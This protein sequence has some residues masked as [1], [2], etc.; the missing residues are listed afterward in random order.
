MSAAEYE[1]SATDW[2]GSTLEVGDG[3][4]P[5]N[6]TAIAEVTKITFGGMKTADIETT[7][8][9]SP[10]AHE[11]NIPGKRSTDAFGV[12]GNWLPDNATQSNSSSGGGGLTYL[13][14]TR[15]IR[16]FQIVM[17]NSGSPQTAWPFRGYVNMFKPGDA[18]TGTKK[19]FEASIKPSKDIA[20]DLP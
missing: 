14:R 4:S 7:H 8:L 11:E 12:S 13:A 19:S 5:E 9:L 1:S 2:A 15:A 20:A 18:E 3:A 10:N 6:F 16:N 17:G